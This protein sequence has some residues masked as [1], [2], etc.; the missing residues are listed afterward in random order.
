MRREGFV[1]EG[2]PDSAIVEKPWPMELARELGIDDR[3]LDSNEDIRKSFV[4][5]RGRLHE[6]PEGI[7][8]MVPTRIVPFALSGLISWPGKLRMG[9]DLVLPRGKERRRREPGRL[10]A[11]AAGPRG[12]GQGRRADRGRHPRRRSRSR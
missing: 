2:G 11:P 3:L 6:F 10:R 8:L 1:I 4:Y 5:S 7:I 12:A 9:M